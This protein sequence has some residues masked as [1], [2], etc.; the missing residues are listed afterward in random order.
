MNPIAPPTPQPAPR[1]PTGVPNARAQAPRQQ[2]LDLK[3]NVHRKLLNRLN[4]EALAQV[5]AELAEGAA[6]SRIA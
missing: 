4:L 1:G 3:A 2:Y 5:A 6:T